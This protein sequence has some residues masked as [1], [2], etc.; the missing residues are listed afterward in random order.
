ML[1]V[2]KVGAHSTVPPR[3]PP[4]PLPGTRTGFT[5]P[6][7]PSVPAAFISHRASAEMVRRQKRHYAQ[8]R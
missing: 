8:D 7:P 2:L 3:T 1:A 4:P 5:P 6:R